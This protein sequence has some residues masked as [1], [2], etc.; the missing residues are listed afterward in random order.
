MQSM[1]VSTAQAAERL[2]L[3][4]STLAKMRVTGRGPSFVKI[5]RA[6]RYRIEDLDAYI[7]QRLR[8]STSSRGL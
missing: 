4:V 8:V 3:S 7:S 2:G 6:V 1:L 5:S